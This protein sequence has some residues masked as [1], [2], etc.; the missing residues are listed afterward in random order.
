MIV[1]GP[2]ILK[3]TSLTNEIF[4]HISGFFYSYATGL[5]FAVKQL[6]DKPLL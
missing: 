6:E 5:F 4:V 2:D 1:L 3:V